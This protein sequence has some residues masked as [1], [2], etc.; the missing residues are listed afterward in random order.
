MRMP[1]FYIAT[2]TSGGPDPFVT[3]PNTDAI[4]DALED[5]HGGY[6]ESMNL[7]RNGNGTVYWCD[8]CRDT[9]IVDIVK[10]PLIMKQPLYRI[11][12]IPIKG[13]IP[14]LTIGAV[15]Q[16]G[17]YFIDDELDT[18]SEKLAYHLCNLLNNK[19]FNNSGGYIVV[20]AISTDHDKKLEEQ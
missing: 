19:H 20:P 15:E 4:I 17:G 6:L 16:I 18:F 14:L 11:A 9:L 1:L 7:N 12:W 10:G 3:R 2:Y 13:D 8:D 5:N